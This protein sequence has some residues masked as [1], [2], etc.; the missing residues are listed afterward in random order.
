MSW[1]LAE[2]LK[3]TAWAIIVAVALGLALAAILPGA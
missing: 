1:V 3:Q 2:D